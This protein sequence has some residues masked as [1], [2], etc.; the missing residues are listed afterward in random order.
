MGISADRS[1]DELTIHGKGIHHLQEPE[2]VL[3][4]GNSG[5]RTRLLLGILAGQEFSATLTGDSSLRVRP[6]RRVTE[7]LRE[8]ERNLSAEITETGCRCLCRAAN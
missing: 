1:G 7:P 5:H 3:N 8:M 2:D 6:M 4:M